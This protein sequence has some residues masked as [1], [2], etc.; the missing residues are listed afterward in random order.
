MSSTE[1]KKFKK[2]LQSKLVKSKGNK[3]S[4]LLEIASEKK[5]D[6]PRPRAKATLEVP[7]EGIQFFASNLKN[8]C[9]IK[10]VSAACWTGEDKEKKLKDVWDSTSDRTDD[11]KR[12][13]CDIKGGFFTPAYDEDVR[14]G[15]VEIDF[16]SPAQAKALGTQPGPSVRLCTKGKSKGVFVP[17]KDPDAVK[18]ITESFQ[19][20][21]RAD[22]DAAACA[23]REA[24]G[25]GAVLAGVR[26]RRS[27]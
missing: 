16:L 22:G 14:S 4:Y 7:G 5:L 10:R 13:K 25:K 26:R 6:I 3:A 17:V 23:A 9:R 11:Q 1:P 2:A 12:Q 21:V 24:E 8:V 15:K 27:R 20:C 19:S 18:K